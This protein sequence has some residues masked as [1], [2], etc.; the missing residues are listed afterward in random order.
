MSDYEKHI[1]KIRKYFEEHKAE[2][3][4]FENE[5]LREKDEYV[6][7]LYF[8]MICTLVRYTG[9]ASEMQ[10]LYI[11]RLIV[12]SNA[13]NKFHDYMK[14][15]L[16][17]EKEDIDEF[18]SIFRADDL[19]YYFCIDGAIVSSLGK[20][21]DKNYELFAELIEL[22]GICRDELTYLVSVSKAIICLSSEQFDKA[23][24]ISPRTTKE[25]YLYHYLESFY[26]GMIIDTPEI[27]H[28]YSHNKMP[29]DLSNY[30]EYKA[31][32]IIIDN[33]TVSLKKDII[34]DGYSEVI[35]RKCI[36]EGNAHSL[37]FNRVGQVVIE[38]CEI[39]DFSNRFAY[40]TDTNNLS[41]LRNHFTNC[42]YIGNDI[43]IKGGILLSIGNKM[44]SVVI[45][46]NRLLNCYVETTTKSLYLIGG[47]TGILLHFENGV[48]NI[49]VI[50]NQFLGCECLGNEDFTE[51][52][53]SGNADSA[54]ET[55]NVCEGSVTKI[56]ENY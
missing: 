15:A 50:N 31:R 27:R 10:V 5:L 7:S 34:F 13:E 48:N 9:E 22:L 2:R 11:R 33:V 23:R 3:Y 49:K 56:F 52:Y 21:T 46:D 45:E 32:R 36:F 42:R 19:K 17:L 28:I 35:I 41:L 14:M 20:T 6:K 1:D 29:V 55:D 53:I 30:T 44:D 38:D 12:G 47:V 51:A 16:D 8:R 24:A 25:L 54:T 37:K 18:I 39:S 40:F 26:T 43:V 4:P